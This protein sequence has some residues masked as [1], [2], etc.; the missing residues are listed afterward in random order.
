MDDFYVYLPISSELRVLDLIEMAAEVIKLKNYEDFKL[1]YFDGLE[2]RILDDD[3]CIPNVSN[4][5]QS[6][7]GLMGK[8]HSIFK[9][10]GK[11]EVFIMKKYLYLSP[12]QERKD[13]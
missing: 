9:G 11:S 6:N 10:K 7:E 12:K 4:Q 1:Y 13:Y 8:I 3:D 5:K 2:N